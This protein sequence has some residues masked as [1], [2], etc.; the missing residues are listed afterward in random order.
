MRLPVRPIA[1]APTPTLRYN[2]GD[3][4]GAYEK[5]IIDDSDRLDRKRH[6]LRA[7]GHGQGEG[8][9]EATPTS[10]GQPLQA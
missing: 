10:L 4:G 5:G 2:V 3:G 6:G 7:A 1:V 9:Q 8:L